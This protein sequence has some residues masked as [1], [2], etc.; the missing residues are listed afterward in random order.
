MAQDFVDT[1]VFAPLSEIAE[2]IR[3][4]HRFL[5]QLIH[6]LGFKQLP[7]RQ[8][9]AWAGEH[10]GR[11]KN[12]G[13][14][15]SRS[16]MTMVLEAELMRSAVIAKRGGWQTLHDNAEDLGLD[17]TLFSELAENALRQAETLEQVHAYAR[18]RAFRDDLETYTP[19]D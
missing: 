9:I 2:E 17:A 15:L 10:I 18:K 5:G 7:H 16:P 11:L 13:R 19:Q 1:P 8:A 6:D 4:E 12:N 14:L 3:A